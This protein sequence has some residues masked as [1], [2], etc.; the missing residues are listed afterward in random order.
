MEAEELPLPR[1]GAA[2]VVLINRTR[3]EV[4][5]LGNPWVIF[6]G[7]A[8][9]SQLA[10]ERVAAEYRAMYLGSVVAAGKKRY[11]IQSG[12][13]D[14][15]PLKI[16]ENSFS[17]LANVY[18]SVFG[19]GALNGMPIASPFYEIIEIPKDCENLVLA[20]AGYPF[21]PYELSEAEA[22]LE[23]TLRG[24]P[25]MFQY[26]PMPIGTQ[27]GCSSFSDRSFLSVAL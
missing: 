20:T 1:T 14:V 3:R 24:D 26:Y 22:E 8:D 17:Q 11:E 2:F 18:G 12:E 15:E 21:P 6:D 10:I 16:F 27:P 5:R 19:Y 7:T 9:R 25:A 13:H 23:R 4:W